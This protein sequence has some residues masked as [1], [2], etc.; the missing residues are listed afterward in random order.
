MTLARKTL[1][2][3]K[4]PKETERREQIKK[5]AIKLFSAS[6]YDQISLDELAQEAGISKAL[7]YW[8]WESKAAFFQGSD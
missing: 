8:Y 5:A 1:G 7:F 2:L 3:R 6:A 4:N